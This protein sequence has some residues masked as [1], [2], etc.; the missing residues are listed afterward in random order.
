VEIE[1]GAVHLRGLPLALQ[2]VAPRRHDG[3]GRR[4]GLLSTGEFASARETVVGAVDWRPT[5]H[6][7]QVPAVASVRKLVEEVMPPLWQY[8]SREGR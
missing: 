2:R 4:A 6:G 8:L 7:P 1:P 5:D 3:T